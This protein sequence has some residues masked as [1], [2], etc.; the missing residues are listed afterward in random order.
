MGADLA[1][2]PCLHK[3][4]VL[5]IKGGKTTSLKDK[6]PKKEKTELDEVDKAY[7]EKQDKDNKAKAEMIKKLAGKK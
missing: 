3:I 7:K 5:N 2:S 1:L 6:R 4:M